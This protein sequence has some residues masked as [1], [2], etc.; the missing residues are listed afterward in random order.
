MDKLFEKEAMARRV[1]RSKAPCTLRMFSKKKIFENCEE[2]HD[3]ESYQIL[4]VT[5]FG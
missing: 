1:D 4:K 5:N 2:F 3:S